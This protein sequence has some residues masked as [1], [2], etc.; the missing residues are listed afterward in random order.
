MRGLPSDARVALRVARYGI[1]RS[2]P[3]ATLRDRGCDRILVLPLYPQYAAEHDRVGRRRARLRRS[4]AC[5]TCRRCARSKHFHDHPATSRRSRKACSDYW[6]AN[7]RPDVLVMSFH[8]VPRRHLDRGDPY[9]CECQKTGRLLAEALGARADR[10]AVTFQSRFGRA[11]WLKPYTADVLE[12]LGSNDVGRVDV[13]C[14][15]FVADCLETL[16][17]IAIEGKAPFPAGGR[18]G[19]P[20]HPLPQR[21]RRLD[22]RARRSRRRRISRAG[23]APNPTARSWNA[24]AVRALAL[25]ASS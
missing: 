23:S 10:Y 5:A 16:E 18:Q 2:R 15:G 25:G 4:R 20:L 13:V 22:P 19:V 11:E 7:G 12:Q 21:A 1:R 14:P 17:E 8:G 24:R 9:H 6:T 3:G